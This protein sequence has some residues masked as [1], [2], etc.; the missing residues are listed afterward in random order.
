MFT[1]RYAV[2]TLIKSPGF[3]AIAVA[4]APSSVPEIAIV[5]FAFFGVD[6]SRADLDFF[7]RALRRR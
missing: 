6:S 3:F 2:R 4:F 5:A 7:D 1:F